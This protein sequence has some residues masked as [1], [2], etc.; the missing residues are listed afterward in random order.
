MWP[1]RVECIKD[2]EARDRELCQAVLEAAQACRSKSQALG[3]SS[4]KGRK[5]PHKRNFKGKID[6]A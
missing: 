3:I 2:T 4:G 6:G 1:D 5:D